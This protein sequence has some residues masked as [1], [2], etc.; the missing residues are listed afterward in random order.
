VGPSPDSYPIP[1]ST[2]PLFVVLIPRG[3][4]IQWSQQLAQPAPGAELIGNR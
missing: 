2:D 3:M 1:R 4:S